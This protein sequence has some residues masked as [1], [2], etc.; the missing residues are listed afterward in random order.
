MTEIKG[1]GKK[2]KRSYNTEEGTTKSRG[3]ND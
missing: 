2:I 3:K 1:C